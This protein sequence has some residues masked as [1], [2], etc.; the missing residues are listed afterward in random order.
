MLAFLSWY[1]LITVVGL[2]A[3]PIAY[4]IFTR[5]PDRGYALARPFGLL[6]WGFIFWLLASLHI[7]Q[8]D[9]GG[10]LLALLLVLG[11]SALVI[12]KEW[13]GFIGWFKPNLKIWLTIECV[14][15]VFFAAWAAVRAFNPAIV[16]TEKPMEMAFINAILRSPTFPPNDPWLSGYSISYYYFGYV[17]VAMLTRLTA[18]EPGVAFNLASALWFAL[19]ATAAYGVLF[20]LINRW[21][22][23]RTPL[24]ETLKTTARGLGMALFGPLFLL[25]VGNLEG[26]LENLYAVGAFW[27]PAA[28]GTYQ[29]RFWAWLDIAELKAAPT[30]LP[31]DWSAWNFLKDGLPHRQAGWLIWRGSRVLTD[32]NLS[33]GAIEII[34]E[35]PFFSYLLADLHP[36]VLAMPFVLL[37]IGLAL[38][39]YL[40]HGRPFEGKSIFDWLRLP[41]FWLNAVIFG[42][43][44]FLNTWDFPIYVALFSAAFILSR[45]QSF[46]WATRRLWEF[47]G[48]AA[49]LGI[50]GVVL[51]LPFYLGFASQAGGI[52]PSGIFVTRGAHFWVMFGVLLVPVLIWLFW[53]WSHN[54]SRSALKAG[55]KFAVWVIGGLALASLSLLVLAPVLESIGRSILSTP[56]GAASRLA[57]SMV[58]W[59]SMIN[60][61]FGASDSGA[62]LGAALQRRITYVGTWL[63]LTTI[64]VLAWGLMSAL[65]RRTASE[66]STSQQITPVQAF[67][68]L[69]A[70]LGAGLALF[71]E[72]FFLRDNFGNRMNTIFKF[73]F[74][75]WII[76]SLV[77]AF[78]SAVL[79]EALSGFRAVIFSAVWSIVLL[80]SLTYPVTMLPY[81]TGNFKVT[82]NYTLDGTAHIERSQ[83]DEMAAIRWLRDAPYGVVAEAVGGAYSSYARI[84]VNTGLP[85]VLGWDNHEGQWRGSRDEIG[86]RTPDMQQLYVSS[87]WEAVKAILVR[88]NIRYVYVGPL[89]RNTYPVNDN[90]F[91]TYL[92]PVF[93]TNTVMIYEVP[94]LEIVP[95]QT[96]P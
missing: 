41:E 67:A 39:V 20:A 73:Y 51:Y 2:L 1:V 4:R 77:A 90:L 87:D 88:Y 79:W 47:I 36:H 69:L 43:L 86:S 60:S 96:T 62:L 17:M 46:G 58:F 68:A 57:N 45:T 83:P 48:V 78:A 37:C 16:G 80:M 42:S 84:S 23:E 63:P 7:L 70:L 54:G 11:A 14:F 27:S 5:L 40:A 81:Y 44:A 33:G 76:W 21:L 49:V 18:V 61:L 75:T 26:I 85:T 95:L 30:H 93:V 29:S 74:Q 82:D 31:F 6:L 10:V 9:L 64:V 12:R 65:K 52:M 35:F 89:E 94:Q 15:L 3:F 92:K 24:V 25:L 34:D 19:T 22:H 59:A 55:G 32:Y 8:N 38:Q 53:S 28:D 56:S 50:A 66:E 72:F 91:Q 13:Q 71:P